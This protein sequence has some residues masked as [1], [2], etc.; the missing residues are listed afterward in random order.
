MRTLICVG[1]SLTEGTDIPAGHTWPELV[2]NALNMEVVNGGIGGDTTTGMMARFHPEVV[3]RKPAFVFIMG[4]TNDL[5]WG[6]SINTV[7]ANLFAMIVQARHH[8]IAPVLALPPPVHL[9]LAGGNDFSPPRDG[10]GG[11]T[12]QMQRLLKE[13]THY[14]DESDVALVDLQRPFVSQTGEIETTLFLPD[15]LHPNREGHQKMATAIVQTFC[16]D[17]FFRV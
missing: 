3:A 12:E 1:D 14:A 4:G 8:S 17:L 16:R 7:L 11:F 5:W 9:E 6:Q 2:G 15:G 13:I 10:Y